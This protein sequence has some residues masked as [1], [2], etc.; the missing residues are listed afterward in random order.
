MGGD[1]HLAGPAGQNPA[2]PPRQESDS[3]AAGLDGAAFS[4]TTT[5]PKEKDL[6][7]IEQALDTSRTS[8]AGR[9]HREE[10]QVD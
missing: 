1:R 3:D 8:I 2:S 5:V 4:S 9:D 7:R 6:D 10:T